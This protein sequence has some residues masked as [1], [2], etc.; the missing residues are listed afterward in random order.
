MKL[1]LNNSMHKLKK[2]VKQK[3]IKKTQHRQFFTKLPKI[4]QQV[5]QASTIQCQAQWAK[6]SSLV[7]KI[8]WPVERCTQVYVL[9][10]AASK[11]SVC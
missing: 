8:F 1:Q 3:P 11:V 2:R 6:D 10:W 5:K 9:V 4:S 7:N